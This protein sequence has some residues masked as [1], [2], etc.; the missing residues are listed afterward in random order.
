MTATVSSWQVKISRAEHHL[1]DLD[2]L[3][4]EYIDGHH[5]RAKCISPLDG[6]D[7]EWIL[8]ITAQPSF[9]LGAILGDYLFNIRSALDHI[10]VAVTQPKHQRDIYFPVLAKSCTIGKCGV[11]RDAFLHA[12]KGMDP[13]AAA[14]IKQSQPFQKWPHESDPSHPGK[15]GPLYVLSEF[16]N[17]DKHR[18]LTILNGGLSDAMLIVRVH[19]GCVTE[20]SPIPFR[21]ANDGAKIGDGNSHSGFAYTEVDVDVVG[22]GHI[23]AVVSSKGGNVWHY[24]ISGDTAI[25]RVILEHARGIISTLEPIARA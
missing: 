22:S 5:Y 1:A 18:A 24:P 11:K 16:Q 15:R 9:L 8:E 6:D 19:G 20:R 13:R 3:A 25:T 7:G 2:S 10:A 23:S 4:A 12:T 14:I 21:H 17:A